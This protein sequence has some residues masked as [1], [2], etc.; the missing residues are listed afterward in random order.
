MLRGF[1]AFFLFLL[2]A[3][4]QYAGGSYACGGIFT[5]TSAYTDGVTV[6]V[7]DQLQDDYTDPGCAPWRTFQHTYSMSISLTSP[8][9]RVA[10]GS[11]G[12]GRNGNSGTGWASAQV[13]MPL[14]I[15][16]GS[17]DLDN[18]NWMVQVSRTVICSVAGTILFKSLP[19]PVTVGASLNAS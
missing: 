3:T 19:I 8:T 13:S 4:A 2:P 5:Y 10:Y 1:F 16:D 6:L 17:G 7:T 11:G 14:E 18:G 15:P 12:G 9:G